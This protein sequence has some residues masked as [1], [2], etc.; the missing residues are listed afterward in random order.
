MTDALHM[1]RALELAA[2]AEGSVSPRPPVGAVVVSAEGRVAGEGWTRP[3]PG[4][5]A[6][7][8]ALQAAGPAARGG[9]LYVTLE[10]CCHTGLTPPCTDAIAASGVARVV[11][12]VRD[13][14]PRVRGR[15]FRLL[16]DAGIDVRT[17]VGRG[18]ASDLIEPF[19]VRVSTG[20]PLVTMKVAASLDGRTAAPDGTSRWIT[21]DRSREQVHAMRARADAVLV[22]SGTVAADDPALTCRLPGFSGRQPLRVVVDSSGRTSPGAAVLDGAAPALVCTTSEVSDEIRARWAAAGADVVE[23]PA[24][25]SGVELGAVLDEL[26]RR[27]ICHVLAE[28]GPNLAAS[29]VA[30]GFAERIVVYLAAKLIGG[31]AP[32]LL[33]AGVKTISDAWP[34]R[35]ERVTRVG[36]DIRVDARLGDR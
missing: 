25:E 2:R 1:R 34:L 26:G 20:R 8:D 3:A 22:G 11:A 13:P 18:R 10:P 4:P 33:A 19:N 5:H 21:G 27:G 30:G 17:G 36:G 29:L 14:D 24:T 12:A 15:G 7:V 6:E 32:G 23:L 28:A 31:E 16:R 35:I 9:T